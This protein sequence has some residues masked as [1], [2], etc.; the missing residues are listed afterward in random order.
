MKIDE[1]KVISIDDNNI[2]LLLVENYAKSLG[3][4]VLNFTNPKEALVYSLKHPHDMV[5]VDYMMPEMNGLEFIEAYRS[6]IK[7]TPVIMLT[8]V[9]DDDALQIK[10]LELGATDFLS[11]PINP[12]A[13]KARITNLMGMRKIQLILNDK[14]LL[15]EEEVR[16]A[17]AKIVAREQE[18]LVVLGKTAEYKDPETGAHISRVAHYSKLLAKWYGLNEH[19]QELIFYASP[20]HDMGKVGIADG[21]LLKPARLDAKEFEIMQQHVRI[22]YDILKEAQSEYLKAGSIIAYTHHEK[23]D[24]SGYPKGLKGESIPIFGRIVAIADVFDALTS[25]RP[26]KKAWSFEEAVSYLESNKGL[27]FDPR[28][29]ECFCENIGEIREIYEMIAQEFPNEYIY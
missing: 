8:A 22:G 28:L 18:T 3:L 20:L 15:L 10:A 25:I 13:F 12:P 5:I 19:M 26:Y 11:K 2:N 29:V 16:K 1:M 9:G 23:Y 14:A 21:I 4:Q 24:G 27:H 17:T 7:E 6:S